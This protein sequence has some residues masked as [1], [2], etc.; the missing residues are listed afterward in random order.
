MTSKDRLTEAHQRLTAAVESLVSGEDW[1][2]LLTLAAHLH[3][4]SSGV[5]VISKA[6]E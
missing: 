5:G 4:Y 3:R 2:Q 6:R 1:Q